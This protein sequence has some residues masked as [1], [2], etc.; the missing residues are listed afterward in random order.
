MRC[1]QADFIHDST[2]NLSGLLV[3]LL[4]IGGPV[5]SL[6]KHDSG[7]LTFLIT[8]FLPDP[9]TVIQWHA[10]IAYGIVNDIEVILQRYGGLQRIC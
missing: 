6:S 8:T 2:C 9:K 4:S 5:V 1:V 10:A 7:A 3:A